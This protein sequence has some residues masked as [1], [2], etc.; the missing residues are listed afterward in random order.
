MIAELIEDNKLSDI[1]KLL[2]PYSLEERRYISSEKVKRSSLL[3]IAVQQSAGNHQIF[4]GMWGQSKRYWPPD[5][6]EVPL[7]L[8]S[9]PS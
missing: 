9:S 1:R 3:Y 6:N 4:L 7:S 5:G 8:E 2:E